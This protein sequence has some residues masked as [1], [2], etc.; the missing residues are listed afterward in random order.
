MSVGGRDRE[1]RSEKIL[2]QARRIVV[3]LIRQTVAATLATTAARAR[4]SVV[5]VAAGARCRRTH[6]AVFQRTYSSSTFA[7][8][9]GVLRKNTR[10]DLIDGSY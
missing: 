10:L 4:G 1:E 8:A 5:K 6:F 3:P 9:H 7:R 2:P